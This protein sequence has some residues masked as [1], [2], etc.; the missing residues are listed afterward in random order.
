MVQ[1]TNE[2]RDIQLKLKV[3]RH[4]GK[5]GDVGK[6][7]RSFGIGTS[8]FCSWKAA[9][10][11]RSEAGLIIQRPISKNAADQTPPEIVEKGRHL[12]SKYRLAFIRFA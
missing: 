11:Q 8:T 10:E 2:E 6:K 7:C 3:P 12:R 5:I 4:A 1:V 9:Y